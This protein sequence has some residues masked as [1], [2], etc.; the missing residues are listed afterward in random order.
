MT[1]NSEIKLE[2]L[3][4]LIE[5]EPDNATLYVERG[6]ELWRIGRRGEAMSDYQRAAALDPEGPGKLLAEHSDRIMEFFNPDLLNP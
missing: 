5:A 6:R 2:E 4:R 1:E 3:N